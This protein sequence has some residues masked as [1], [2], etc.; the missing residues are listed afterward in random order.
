MIAEEQNKKD[1]SR[2]EGYYQQAAEVFPEGGK[3]FQMRL[4]DH[5]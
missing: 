2:A 5:H 4:V 3:S 1:W